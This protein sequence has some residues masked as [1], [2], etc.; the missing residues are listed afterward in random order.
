M[1][2]DGR[3]AAPSFFCPLTMALMKDPVQ[4]R[5]GIYEDAYHYVVCELASNDAPN[6]SIFRLQI[7]LNSVSSPPSSGP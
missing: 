3:A 4:D 6:R 7:V 1:L 2:E 5:E